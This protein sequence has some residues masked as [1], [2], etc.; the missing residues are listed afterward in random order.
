MEPFTNSSRILLNISGTKYEVTRKSLLT[1]PSSRL[2][3]LVSASQSTKQEELHFNRPPMCFES[4]LVFYQTGKLHLPPNVCPNVFK[5]EL[6]YWEIDHEL[7]EQCCLMNYM[8]FLEGYKTKT[9]FKN[10]IIQSDKGT[11]KPCS[12]KTRIWRIIDYKERTWLAKVRN[13]WKEHG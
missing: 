12:G 11:S 1:H 10:S 3:K 9:E 2:G 7:M 8:Q 5:E 6:E 13:E 4:I